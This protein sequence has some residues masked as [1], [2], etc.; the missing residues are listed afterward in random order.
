[1]VRLSS[2]NNLK[3]KFPR[4]AKQWH[5]TKNGE[6]TPENVTPKSGKKVWW[7]CEKCGHEWK[8]MVNNRSDKGQGCPE[9]GRKKSGETLVKNKIAKIGSLAD[10]SDVAKEWHPTKNGKLTPYDVTSGSA[11]IVWWVC[12]KGHEWSARLNSRSIGGNGC[13]YCSN[14]KIWNTGD[15]RDN[16]LAAVNSEVAAEWH[17][18]KNG[19]LTP[20]DVSLRSNKKVWWMCE[21]RHGWEAVISNRTLRNDGCP[22]CYRER[23]RKRIQK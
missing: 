4:L 16:T 12:E 17:P 9:C 13:P 2:E 5:P 20:Y 15:E 3:R 10:N 18:T 22:K 7:V 11:K 19:E 6:L 8:A 23:R 1:M 14:Q 21:K